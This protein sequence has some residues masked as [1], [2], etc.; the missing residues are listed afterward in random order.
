MEVEIRLKQFEKAA[1][2]QAEID[3]AKAERSEIEQKMNVNSQGSESEIR[4]GSNET[5]SSK[6]DV[7]KFSNFFLI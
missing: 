6:L 2:T 5:F 3:K 4:V 1:E 7:K